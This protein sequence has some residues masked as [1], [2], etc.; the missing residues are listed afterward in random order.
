MNTTAT[1]EAS[2][3]CCRRC[4]GSGYLGQF[5]HFNGGRCF[6]CDGEGCHGTPAQRKVFQAEMRA[7]I[8]A[9]EAR[10]KATQREETRLMIVA[11]FESEYPGGNY[12]EDVAAW[13]EANA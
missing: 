8:K 4:G 13:M 12:P 7:S 11:R 2:A 5:S 1:A 9:E 6:G 3:T 10:C